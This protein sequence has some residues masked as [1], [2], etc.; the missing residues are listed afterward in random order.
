MILLLKS[1]KLVFEWNKQKDLENQSKHN[2]SFTE[3]RRA[4][5]DSRKVIAQDLE[6][7]LN[8]QR[9][10]CLGKINTAVVTVRFTFRLNKIRI[11]GA[12]FWR[13][14]RKTYEKENSV[15]R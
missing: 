2:I 12:G 7:S 3:A 8:E 1:T 14:G 13:K 6:R 9:W 4:F 5:E 15:H 10:F 11:I